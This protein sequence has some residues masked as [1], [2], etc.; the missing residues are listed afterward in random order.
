MRQ[1]QP[2]E[3]DEQHLDFV[4][5]L[6]CVVCGDDTCTEAAHIRSGNLAYGKENTGMQ[7]KPHDRWTIPL[8]GRCHRV[9]HTQNEWR[10]WRDLKINPWTLAMT[11][12]NI[13]G[14]HEMALTAI[15]RHR[16]PAIP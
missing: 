10:F 11:L 15:E 1:R 8:C 16:S 2:R 13:S 3:T 4:R 6:P 12:H 5:S 7:Q 14:N 9:Q